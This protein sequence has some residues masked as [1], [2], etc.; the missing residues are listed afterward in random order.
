[1]NPG[2]I[3]TECV[4]FM[5]QRCSRDVIRNVTRVLQ[6]CYKGVSGMLQG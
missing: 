5:Q 1:M 3:A 2:Q 6:G 4:A